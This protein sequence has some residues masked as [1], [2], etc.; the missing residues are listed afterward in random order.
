MGFAYT[1]DVN[2]LEMAG[3]PPDLIFD[4]PVVAGYAL[5]R[6]RYAPDDAPYHVIR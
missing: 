4:Y 2:Y 6:S 3:N 5:P 1:R